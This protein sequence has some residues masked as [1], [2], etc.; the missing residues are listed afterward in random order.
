MQD[1]AST[2]KEY[3]QSSRMVFDRIERLNMLIS[4]AR[5]NGAP[6]RELLDRRK[7]LYVE[8]MELRQAIEQMEEYLLPKEWRGDQAG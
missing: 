6:T 1:I 5:Q 2:L 8:H 4:N 7:L 3:R